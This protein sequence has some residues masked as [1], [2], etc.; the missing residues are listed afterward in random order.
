[1]A[2]TV[3]NAF[4]DMHNRQKLT[5]AQSVNA[6]TREGAIRTFFAN[7]FD[8]RE[9]VF[10]IGSYKRGTICGGER[11]I[12]LMAPLSPFSANKYWERYEGDS[13]A[14]LYW[15]RDRLNERYYATKVSSKR[16]CVKLDFTDIVTDVT[17]CFPREGGGYLMPNGRGGWMNT[18]PP[19]HTNLIAGDDA[20]AEERLKPLIRLIKAWNIANGHHLSSFH[21][22]LMVQRVQ[23][24]Q[25]IHAYPF[26]VSFTL[27][28]LPEQLGKS[29]DDPW[30][31]G[32]RI[33][34]YLT[35]D[36]R[37]LVLRLLAEDSKRSNLAEEYRKEGKTE[38]AF[39]EWNKIYHGTFPT[40]G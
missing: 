20:R 38:K 40:Y 34:E 19:F 35:K 39:E 13:S 36:T 8:M 24:G 5:P 21:I 17:P 31:S 9:P 32:G 29:L 16:V 27:T 6:R 15:V 18:N 37:D 25:S 26:E 7:N 14:F 3:G 4:A 2:T 33:D 1:M 11:D 28:Y 23:Q 10:A 30:S 22:E 12:D